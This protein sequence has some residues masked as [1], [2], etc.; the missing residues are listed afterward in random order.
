MKTFKEGQLVISE[1]YI[2]AED[3]D[4]LL[5]YIKNTEEYRKT[6]TENNPSPFQA[7]NVTKRIQQSIIPEQ[8]KKIFEKMNLNF[9]KITE[10]IKY[11]PVV[12]HINTISISNV[13]MA[14]HADGEEPLNIED[15]GLG[16]PNEKDH[17]G[18]NPPKSQEWITNKTAGRV[19]TS[20]VYLNSNFTGGE[21]TFPSKM[22]D[23]APAAGKLVAFP[24]SRDYIHGVRPI[25]N[26]PR[27]AIPS[28][29]QM[30]LDAANRYFQQKD[31]H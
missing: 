15:R 3:V 9:S 6:A 23:V 24:C 10:I 18:Y 27:V 8:I 16:T 31:W 20:I 26:G 4:V 14:Y 19:F 28:W 12:P 11:P 22:I 25:K 30:D 13:P 1:N 29:Y 7:I 21:T 5:Q 17:T 2:P